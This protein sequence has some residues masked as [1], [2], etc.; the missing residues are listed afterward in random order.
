[1][2]NF[3]HARIPSQ[4]V[5]A[6]GSVHFRTSPGDTQGAHVGRTRIRLDHGLWTLFIT[7]KTD[8][9]TVMRVL[10]RDRDIKDT[11]VHAGERDEFQVEARVFEDDEILEI[12]F[13]TAVDVHGDIIGHSR[14]IG[15]RQVAVDMEDVLDNPM[16]SATGG[17]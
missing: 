8:A 15:R 3:L 13:D 11:L 16:W 7:V 10:L 9:D 6:G 1:M 5:D 2:S 4:N 12:Q 17:L 14:R